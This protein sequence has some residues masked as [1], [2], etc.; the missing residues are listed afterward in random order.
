LRCHY[1]DIEVQEPWEY[2]RDHFPRPL[3]QRGLATVVACN[4]CHHKKDRWTREQLLA[5]FD[6]VVDGDHGKPE[7]AGY[8]YSWRAFLDDHADGFPEVAFR[9]ARRNWRA[10]P[11]AFRLLAGRI[12]REAKWH[13][14]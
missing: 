14:Q 12:L 13:R 9:T 11:V 1:C 2:Q 5:E 6:A 3:S 8:Y 7:V 4:A 10:W